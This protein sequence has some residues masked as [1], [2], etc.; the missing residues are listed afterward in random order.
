MKCPDARLFY[1]GTRVGATQKSQEN[2]VVPQF[3]QRHCWVP[4]RGGDGGR[5]GLSKGLWIFAEFAVGKGEQVRAFLV[6][7]LVRPYGA[8]PADV[9]RRNFPRAYALSTT[10]RTELDF[11]S[12]H[13]G[14]PLPLSGRRPDFLINPVPRATACHTAQPKALAPL[15]VGTEVERLHS[16]APA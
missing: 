7:G 1:C 3:E 13:F 4:G 14:F 12:V 16:C 15:I 8:L 9:I 10:F 6:L 11:A 2:Q 5:G